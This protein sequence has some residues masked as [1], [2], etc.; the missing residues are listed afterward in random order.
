[1]CISAEYRQTQVGSNESHFEV[2]RC[3]TAL[4]YF[5]ELVVGVI[6][7]GKEEDDGADDTRHTA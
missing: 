5:A 2:N 4:T 7:R 6:L 1:M 3:H